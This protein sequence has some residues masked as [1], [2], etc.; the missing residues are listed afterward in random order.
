MERAFYKTVTDKVDELLTANGFTRN[1]EGDIEYYTNADYAV[2][3]EYNEESKLLELKNAPLQEGESSDFK[4]MSSWLLD[5]NSDDRDKNSIA[6]DFVDSLSELIGIKTSTV[7]SRNNVDLPSKKSKADTIDIE[8]MAARFLSLFPS[9]KDDYKDNVAKYSEFL[10]DK[11]FGEYAVAEF[12]RS[13]KEDDKKLITKM[14]DWLAECY[15]KGDEAVVNT[16][17]YTVIGGSLADDEKLEKTFNSYVEAD[18]YKYLKNAAFYILQYL[19]KGDNA[20]KYL[21]VN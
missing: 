7:V 8:T 6:N 9:H 13:L 21:K 16:V 15:I 17:M 12:K 10:Y 3:I 14:L 1:T 4:V 19:K 5:E 11:F 18:K 2:R 20:K